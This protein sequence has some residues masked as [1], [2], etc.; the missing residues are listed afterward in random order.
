[1]RV[2]FEG[3]FAI[4]RHPSFSDLEVIPEA[5]F[6]WSALVGSRKAGET[7]L[8]TVARGT[9]YW[10][11]TGLAPNP[12]MYGVERSPWLSALDEAPQGLHHYILLGQDDYVEILAKGWTWELGQVLA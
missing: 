4:R 1:M 10:R 5:D 11:E 3:G 9:K 12:G 6:D 8:E 2:N 7:V